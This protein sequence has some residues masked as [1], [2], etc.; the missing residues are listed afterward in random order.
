MAGSNTPPPAVFLDGNIYDR[1]A[2][3]HQTRERLVVLV[4]NGDVRVIATPVVADEVTAGPLRSLPDWFPIDLRNEAVAVLGYAKLGMA[5]LGEGEMYQAHR[6]ESLTSSNTRDAIIAES[7]HKL[8]DLFV[9][10][11]RRSRERLRKLSSNCAAMT[12]DEFRQW[13]HKPETIKGGQ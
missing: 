12:F 8:A 1:L 10:E 13:L 4:A 9:S 5:Q 7:A 3:D 11:D 6:G 2:A